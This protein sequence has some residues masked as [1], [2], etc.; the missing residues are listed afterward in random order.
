MTT[1]HL[2]HRRLGTVESVTTEQDVSMLRLS[3]YRLLTAD[4]AA[5]RNLG[6]VAGPTA[7]AVDH[8]PP[9]DGGDGP[10]PR[11]GTGSGRSAWSEYAATKQVSVP[12]SASRDEIIELVAAAGV[13]TE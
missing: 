7:T 12:E 6:D 8:V 2:V 10:P 5:E 9:D 4:E 3:G 11:T 13:R 1:F